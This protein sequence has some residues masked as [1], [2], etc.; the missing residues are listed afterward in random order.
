MHPYSYD[1]HQTS[2]QAV[3]FGSDSSGNVTV[4]MNDIVHSTALPNTAS[5]TVEIGFSTG[6]AM[7]R[8]AQTLHV[9]IYTHLVYHYVCTVKERF[10]QQLS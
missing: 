5:Q 7:L 4:K 2:L 1:V 6:L 8:L 9:Y 10:D 3:T